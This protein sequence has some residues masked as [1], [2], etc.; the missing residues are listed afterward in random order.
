[1]KILS[2]DPSTNTGWCLLEDGLLIDYGSIQ[3]DSRLNI[4][5]RLNFVHLE[6]NRL[7][8]RFKPDFC[9]IEDVILSISGAKVLIYL[10]RINGV[11]LNTCYNCVRDNIKTYFPTEWKKKSLDGISGDS[12]KVDIQ[13]AVL[14][15]FNYD[16]SDV[17][18]KYNPI[19]SNLISN[20]QTLLNQYKDTKIESDKLK[21]EM[22]LKRFTGDS[23]HQKVLIQEKNDKLVV[24]KKEIKDNEKKL[25]TVQQKYSLDLTAKC[26]IN[27]N[28]ADSISIAWCA[29]REL[30]ENV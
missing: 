25:I 20:E 13:L 6:V 21:N 15:K 10:S 2:F 7:L 27:D 8:D 3:L 16:I 17:E 26:G 22:K 23:S 24:I 11:I 5:Q 28:I 14:K 4:F 18:L 30:N 12:K 1:M 9:S 29:Y 19:L